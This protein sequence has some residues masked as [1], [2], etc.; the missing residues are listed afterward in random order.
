MHRRHAFGG[1]ALANAESAALVERLAVEEVR[2]R[3]P[4]VVVGHRRAG[5]LDA[6]ARKR[7]VEKDEAVGFGI[8]QRPQQHGADDGE[9]RG[10]GADAERQRQDGG[11][12]EG[13]ILAEQPEREAEILNQS[14]HVTL[15]RARGKRGSGRES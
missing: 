4:I 12:R 2:E 10:V 6:R 3:Q 1:R 8:R 15:P 7:V 9:D 11:Q 5:A 13:A 14:F